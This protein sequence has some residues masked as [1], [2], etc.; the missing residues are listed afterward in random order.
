MT[1]YGPTALASSAW[2]CIAVI[3]PA[4][5]F[6]PK[7]EWI[8]LKIPKIHRDSGF[9]IPICGSYATVG[10]LDFSILR[11]ASQFFWS[12][13]CVGDS[14]GLAQIGGMYGLER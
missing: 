6:P 8:A 14:H 2:L 1:K 5:V 10:V 13:T 4:R 7:W 11:K 12:E 9:D 3:C